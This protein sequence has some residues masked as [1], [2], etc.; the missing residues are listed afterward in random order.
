MNAEETIEGHQ[1]E[2]YRGVEAGVDI[3]MTFVCG[4]GQRAGPH[5]SLAAGLVSVYRPRDN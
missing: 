1:W 2:K 3:Y 4:R 5:G